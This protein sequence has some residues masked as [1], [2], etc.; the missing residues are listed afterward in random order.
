LVASAINAVVAVVLLRAGR[1][2]GS[3]VLEAD[4]RHLLTDVWTSAGGLAGLF[5]VW[6]TKFHILDPL[7]A[8]GGLVNI[9]W[10]G[11]D[12][13]RRPFNGL[14]D[15]ALP[16][17]EQAAVRAAIEARLGPHMD[18]HALRTRQAGRRRFAD[19]HL[20]VPGS[21]TVRQAHALTGE[22]EEAVR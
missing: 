1:K 22:V 19:F 4:G 14:M 10:A 15:H 8:L 2:Y 17:S 9:L 7:L 20:L 3:I 18:Y 11:F 5:L 16:E 21:F 13:I 6:L 12:M